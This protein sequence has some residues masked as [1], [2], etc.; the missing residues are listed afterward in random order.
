VSVCSASTG[1]AMRIDFHPAATAELEDSANWYAERSE[2]AA[3][4]FAMAVDAAIKKIS[5]DPG[6]FAKIDRRHGACNLE[7]Y[8]FQI[9]FRDE[10]TRIRVVAVAHA[11]RRPGY[12]RN[13]S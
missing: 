13:R 6:R 4:G 8:P 1:S 2:D 5:D 12:W 3:R 9:V 7:R 11:K 10:G